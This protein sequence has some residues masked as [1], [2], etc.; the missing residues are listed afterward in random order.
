M[1]INSSTFI[2]NTVLFIR[3][4]LRDQ[5]TDPLS[6]TN[7]LEFIM[8]AYPKRLVQYPIITIKQINII[9]RKL[10]MQSEVH[11]ATISLEVRIWARNAKECDELTS[12]VIDKL[13]D[14]QYS[15]TGT[16]NEDIFGFNISSANSIVEVEGD[17]SI[18]SKIL[19]IEYRAI[20]N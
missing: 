9:T 16:D 5:L 8:T 17:N 4:L 14:N 3:D 11:D 6:R 18:H 10:G 2:E 15:A 1:A 12:D 7:N 20:L 13:R 19:G